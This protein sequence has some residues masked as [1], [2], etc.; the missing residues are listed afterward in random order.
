MPQP[1]KDKPA[2]PNYKELVEFLVRPFLDRPNSLRIDCE[3]LPT[4]NRVWIRMAFEG[5][6]RGRFFGRGGRNIQAMRSALEGIA[7]VAG[8]SVCLDVYGFQGSGKDGDFGGNST[9]LG[10]GSP[11]SNRGP[12]SRT[13]RSRPARSRPYRERS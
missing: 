3:F 4:S 2:S 11:R 10:R 8:Q 7:K 6:D 5:E 9:G 1:K 12:S 13:P